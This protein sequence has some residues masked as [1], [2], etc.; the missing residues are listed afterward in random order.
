MSKGGKG[1]M[2]IYKDIQDAFI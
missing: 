1:N 2:S